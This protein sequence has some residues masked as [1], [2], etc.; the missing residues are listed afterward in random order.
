MFRTKSLLLVHIP[1]GIIF[2]LASAFSMWA[3][4]DGASSANSPQNPVVASNPNPNGVETEAPVSPSSAGGVNQSA[5]AAPVQSGDSGSSVTPSMTASLPVAAPSFW[6]LGFQSFGALLLVL[7][8]ILMLSYL[9]KRLAPGRFGPISQ[10]RHLQILETAALGDKRSVLLIQAG[11]QLLLL[12]STSAQITVLDKFEAGTFFS[13]S[14]GTPSPR[15]AENSR[16]TAAPRILQ[17][18]FQKISHGKQVQISNAKNAPQVRS[19]EEIL[20]N[21]LNQTVKV[22]QPQA[23]DPVSRL[24]AI[25]ESLQ[26]R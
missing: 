9:L 25:R 21:T 3:S 12:G 8:F 18:L 14:E 15:S 6:S 26:V 11:P 24:T 7:G 13:T 16:L 23:V 19:F 17:G 1:L 5:G 22:N 2:C 20:G 4:P 10:K